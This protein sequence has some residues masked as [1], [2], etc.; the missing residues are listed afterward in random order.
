MEL[1][2]VGCFLYEYLLWFRE[3]LQILG[4]SKVRIYKMNNL[5]IEN[6]SFQCL[7]NQRFKPLLGQ[8]QT[9]ELSSHHLC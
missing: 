5:E 2:I 3:G 9:K 1:I 6:L 8:N 4:T 7:A